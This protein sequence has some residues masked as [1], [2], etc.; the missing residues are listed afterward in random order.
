[1][2]TTNLDFARRYFRAIE[3]GATGEALAAFFHPEVTQVEYPNR[4]VPAGATRDL[5]AL[6]EGAERGQ[7]V[8]ASQRY[9]VRHTVE[10]GDSLALEVAWSATLKVPVGS[11]PAGGTMRA[12]FGVFLTFREGRILSQH[13]Y[14][15]FEPF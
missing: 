1:M 2:S 9:E 10:Q 13:N 7:K 4:L 14:D 5:R 12:S 3:Q 8:V 15:C 11:L 6:L